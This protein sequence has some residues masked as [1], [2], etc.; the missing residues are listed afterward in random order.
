M[1]ILESACRAE[2]GGEGLGS[3]TRKALSAFVEEQ[4][5]RCVFVVMMMIMIVVD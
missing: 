3:Q 4:K 2:S 5:E 1:E